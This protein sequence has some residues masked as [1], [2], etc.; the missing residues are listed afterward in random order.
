MHTHRECD[1]KVGVGAWILQCESLCP[2]ND[3]QRKKLG[4][5]F[6]VGEWMLTWALYEDHTWLCHLAS[7][8]N[9]QSSDI[10]RLSEM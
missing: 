9:H 8:Q 7:S 4:S 1:R 2:N 3:I 5:G 10:L 6:G